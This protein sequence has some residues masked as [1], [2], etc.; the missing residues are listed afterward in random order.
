MSSVSELK[1]FLSLLL[2]YYEVFSATENIKNICIARYRDSG[3]EA[4]KQEVGR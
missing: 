2:W 3:K 4:E 1:H